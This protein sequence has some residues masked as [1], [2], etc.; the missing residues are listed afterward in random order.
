[1]GCGSHKDEFLHPSLPQLHEIYWTRA[2]GTALE[3]HHTSSAPQITLLST[4][5]KWRKPHPWKTQDFSD[6]CHPAPNKSLQ[7]A[8]K[9]RHLAG[10]SFP[11]FY[12]RS[13]L[14]SDLTVLDFRYSPHFLSQV[15]PLIKSIDIKIHLGISF[16]E[17]L[18]NH[19]DQFT[20]IL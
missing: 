4:T 2:I 18:D 7:T 15:F 14:T 3:I 11:L 17:N 16:S 13:G 9:S 20:D 10:L 19:M 6:G 8:Q 5:E 1:M 12:S